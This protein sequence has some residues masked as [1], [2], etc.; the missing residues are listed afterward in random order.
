MQIE[1]N[2][3]DVALAAKA[4]T[5]MIQRRNGDLIIPIQDG[6]YDLFRGNGFS[7]HARFRIIKFRGTQGNTKQIF[8]VSGSN[9]NRELCENL[10][11]EFS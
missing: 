7:H 8:Q 6:L 4:A 5:R 2:V 11:K 9:M 3:K 10:L 1:Q